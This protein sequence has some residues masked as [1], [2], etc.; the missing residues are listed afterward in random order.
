MSGAH[1]PGPVAVALPTL[2]ELGER[3]AVIGPV[4]AGKST[5]AAAIAQKTGA[6]LF[7]LDQLHHQPGTE[8]QARPAEEFARLHAEA[9]AEAFW[10]MDGNYS[11]HMPERLARATS[12]VWLALPLSIC[13][14]RYLHRCLSPRQRRAGGLPGGSERFKWHM[15]RHILVVQPK[16]V[17]KMQRLVKESGKPLILL[18]RTGEVRQAYAKWGLEQPAQ[19]S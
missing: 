3:V 17:P 13:V 4:G 2:A 16:A 12:I 5:L 1:P 10:V 11:R 6:T 9:V 15:L 7:H 14:H 18:R 19:T 8:W